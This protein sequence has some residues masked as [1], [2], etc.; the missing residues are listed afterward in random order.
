M[1]QNSDYKYVFVCGL[2]RSGTSVLGRNIAR[3]EDCTGFKNTGA[4]GDE[5]QFL[6]DVYPIAAVYGGA[7][8]FGF[9]PRTHRTETSELLTPENV[10]RLR[11]SW[12]TYWDKSKTIC[13]EKTPGNLLMTRFLQAA[14]PNSCFVVIRRH[15]VPVSMSSQRWKVNITPLHS[16]FKHWLHCHRL[17]EEDEKYL[18][19]VYKLRYEDYVE[20]PDKYHREIARFI[21]TRV[22][23]PPKEDEFRYVAQSLNPAGLRVPERAMEETSRAYD[24]KYFDRWSDLLNNS[25]FKDYYR[26]IARKY[27]SRFAK[28]GYSLTKDLGVSEEVLQGGKASNAIGILGCLGADIG[29]SMRRFSVRFNARLRDV[30]KA[31][32][33]EF[34]VTRI[35]H[36]RQKNQMSEVRT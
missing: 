5:G 12:H 33:P 36:A 2:A 11:A 10:A 34:V 32:L 26:Y 25:F 8:R 24:K 15:P 28:Y 21:G 20:D 7:G 14:F 1:M 29:A 22:P 31:V 9:N 3:L 23:E 17:F 30:A 35:R 18:K 13:V 6:Q 16:L 19:H 4:G 27:E